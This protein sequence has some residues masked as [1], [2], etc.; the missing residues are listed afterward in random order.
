MTADL[1]ALAARGRRTDWPNG[2]GYIIETA[3]GEWD[4]WRPLGQ[5]S[6][7]VAN[8]VPCELGYVAWNGVGA[9]ALQAIAAAKPIEKQKEK[10]RL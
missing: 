8:F 1:R 9:S 10:V 3:L 2:L 5:R 4:L 7:W 6:P